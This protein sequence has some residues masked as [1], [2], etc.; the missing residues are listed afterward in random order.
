MPAADCS[1]TTS[2]ASTATA[3]SAVTAAGAAGGGEEGCPPLPASAQGSGAS[4]PPLCGA[5]DPH[6]DP[7]TASAFACWVLAAAPRLVSGLGPRVVG[8]L[9]E[10][11]SLRRWS[12]EL[13]SELQGIQLAA[14]FGV[15]GQAHH[16]RGA[17]VG[18]RAD[19]RFDN[20]S[21]GAGSRGGAWWLWWGSG[22][23]GGN[24]DPSLYL[25]SLCVCRQQPCVPH[26]APQGRA[27]RAPAENQQPRAVP[28][29]AVCLCARCIHSDGRRGSIGRP[30]GFGGAG[31]GEGGTYYRTSLATYT[32]H[33]LHCHTYFPIICSARNALGAR[34]PPLPVHVLSG[35]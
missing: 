8:L 27:R 13:V 22:F 15:G 26:R 21:P 1:A 12:P 5:L 16:H 14:G 6:W 19:R 17:G 10:Q 24:L 25:P 3:T 29:H 7:P 4:S 34:P 2:S 23:M 32:P 31:S 18:G 20:M 9:L 11:P 33:F 30:R 35:P 28:G